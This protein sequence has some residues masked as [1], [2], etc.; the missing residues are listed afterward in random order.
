MKGRDGL[1]AALRKPTLD[2]THGFITGVSVRGEEVVVEGVRGWSIASSAEI[3][4]ASDIVSV[5]R[6]SR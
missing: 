5:F 4:S 6:Y 2:K 3:S 1:S